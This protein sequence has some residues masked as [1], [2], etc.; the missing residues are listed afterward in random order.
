MAMGIELQ[1]NDEDSGEGFMMC[2]HGTDENVLG[3]ALNVVQLSSDKQ[4]EQMILTI[5]DKMEN[6]R[7]VSLSV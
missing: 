4:L 5:L 6:I 1:Q 2:L 3:Q 7:S